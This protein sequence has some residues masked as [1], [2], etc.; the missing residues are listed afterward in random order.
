M[1][2]ILEDAQFFLGRKSQVVKNNAECERFVS[3]KS[4]SREHELTEMNRY[5]LITDKGKNL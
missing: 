5:K 4:H 2:Q 3:L 1:Y